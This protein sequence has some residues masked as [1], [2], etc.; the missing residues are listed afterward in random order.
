MQVKADWDMNIDLNKLRKEVDKDPRQF[1][2]KIDAGKKKIVTGDMF[3]N[4]PRRGNRVTETL[5]SLDREH[6]ELENKLGQKGHSTIENFENLIQRVTS[7]I[8]KKSSYSRKLEN[9]F[10]KNQQKQA[11]KNKKLLEGDQKGQNDQKLKADEALK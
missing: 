1:Y 7:D 8:D 11:N 9:Q 10:Q 3:A 5:R 6:V 2:D 4:S